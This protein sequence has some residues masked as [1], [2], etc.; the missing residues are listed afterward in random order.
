MV[1]LLVAAA[2]VLTVVLGTGVSASAVAARAGASPIKVLG[3]R[4]GSVIVSRTAAGARRLRLGATVLIARPVGSLS[5]QLNGHPIRLPARAGRVRVRLD[6]ADGLVVGENLLWASA[7][8]RRG[9][10]R[11]VVPVRFVVGYRDARA[12]AIHLRLGL[13]TLP[14]AMARLRLPRA[15]VQSL[16]V[17]I[18]EAQVR[19]PAGAR[20]LDL[21]QLG[22]VRWGANRLRVRLIMSDGRIAEWSRIFSLDRRRDVAVAHLDA[23]AVVGRT[24]ALDAGRSLI[25][26]GARQAR[27]FRWVLLRRPRLSHAR[28][29]RNRGARVRLRPDV[30][31]HY[32]IALR[33]GHGSLQGYDLQDVSVTYPE[34][35][36]P[37]ISITYHGTTPGI[38]VG[39]TFYADTNSGA[40]WAIAL[41]RQTL[42]YD[43][44]YALPLVPTS[45][46]LDRFAQELRN[47]P[48][49]DMVIVIHPGQHT[50][51]LA[52]SSLSSLDG[53][54]RAIGGTLPAKWTYPA[55]NCWSGQTGNCQV[56]T[57]EHV[58][59][60]GWQQGAFDGGSF[61]VIGVPGLAVGQAW[62][63][64]AA[65][66]DSQDGRIT[67]YLTKGIAT[68]TGDANDYT[69]ING[70]PDQYASIDTCS[71]SDGNSCTVRIGSTVAGTYSAGSTTITDV[72]PDVTT[73]IPS[74]IE[75]PGIQPGTFIA[76]GA[77]T[78]SLTITKPTT[79]AATGAV[80]TVTSYLPPPGA[81]GLHVVVLDRTTLRTILNQTVTNTTG[82]L[83][84]LQDSGPYATVGHFLASPGMD[85]QR[86]VIIQSV[87]NGAMSGT[88][89]TALLQ[90]L[91]QLGGTPDLLPYTLTAHKYALVGAATNLP[92]R[93]PSA[94]ESSTAI[95]VIPGSNRFQAGT[96]S[97]ALERDR[98]GLYAPVSGDPIGATNVDL[99]RILYQTAQP[100]PYAE[101]TQELAYIAHNIDLGA[102]PDVRSAYPD[103]NLRSSWPFEAAELRDL[104]CDD[105]NE[106]GPKFQAVKS[107]L[108]KEFSWVPKVYALGTNLLSPY[109]QVGAAPYFDVAQVTNQVKSSVPVPSTTPVKMGWLSIMAD[110]V[111]LASSLAYVADVPGGATFGLISSAGTL[112]TEVMQP[113]GS[114]GGPANEVISTAENL[115]AQIAQQQAAYAQWVD[116][117]EA[118][119][120]DDYGKLSAVGT[121]IGNNTAWTWRPTTTGQAITAL[122]ANTTASAYSALE[123]VAWPAYNLT[124]LG[125]PSNDVNSFSCASAP[126][127]NPFHS[128]MW[129]QNQFLAATSIDGSGGTVDE[130]WTFADLNFGVWSPAN[131]S[132]NRTA[133]M[134][135]TSLTDYIYGP[136]ATG[137]SQS[138]TWYYGGYQYSLGYPQYSPVWWRDTYNPPG[139]VQ[140][141]AVGESSPVADY[142]SQPGQQISSPP[143]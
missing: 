60:V 141:A 8:P 26:P 102:Y 85:D 63:E 66:A 125:Q 122:Q 75:G 65:Q 123:P 15:G 134:P 45:N 106:C 91:D 34:P 100:W 82:L 88:A 37:L 98:D 19:V 48:N 94:L 105:P 6:A 24:I 136:Y 108:L 72:S 21:A 17:T 119:M 53:A 64:T 38:Q 121:A 49:T 31:G 81:N 50:P 115:A 112:A 73:D 78:S 87:G 116:Q 80:L 43:G 127:H 36:V 30:P 130:V 129:P 2:I 39:N 126:P 13:G 59:F 16:V 55:A 42:A 70:G 138:G 128:A 143:P 3:P 7:G 61:T 96:I 132:S 113:P 74:T 18:N 20:V 110:V 76:S 41:D 97:G 118:I 137:H 22:A 10:P 1:A 83:S 33:A 114:N 40:L 51:A 57:F 101:D 35:L 111:G 4:A 25:V 52:A 32:L 58:A 68:A 89:T 139:Y 47:T 142:A 12:L 5:I 84:A 133:S 14:S 62:R 79:A 23:P 107:E 56:Q 120:L 46:D 69:V 131:L 86:L 11:W 93:N 28:L 54:L 140:C 99:Y 71:N 124:G 90:Y 92:W 77:G 27:G 9:P 29:A 103:A 95:P 44:Y 67:G 117:M 104:T 109:Q 135:T